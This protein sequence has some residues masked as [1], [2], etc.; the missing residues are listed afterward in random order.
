MSGV[1]AM[2]GARAMSGVRALLRETI[3]MNAGRRDFPK[4]GDGFML[5]ILADMA[6]RGELVLVGETGDRLTYGLPPAPSTAP[7]TRRDEKKPG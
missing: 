7:R 4:S 2:S 1:R 6:R 5:A 3:P